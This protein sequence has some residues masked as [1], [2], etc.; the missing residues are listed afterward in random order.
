MNTVGTEKMVM[1]SSLMRFFSRIRKYP[2]FGVFI[3]FLVIFVIFSV[4]APKFLTLANL[5]GVFTIVSE[6]GII[7]IGV[8]LLM[9][10]GEFNLAVSGIYVFSAFLFATLANN[11]YSPLALLITL[12]VASFWGYVGGIITLRMH[13]P[14][15]IT[16]LGLLMFL[17]GIMLAITKGSSIDYRGDA[18][19]PKM[20]AK[21]I[22]GSF[23]PS[24]FWFI[25]LV[26]VFA[27]ILTRTR[28]GNWVFATGGAKEVARTMGVNVDRVKLINFTISGVLAGFSGCIVLSRFG[29]A[30]PSFGFGLELEAIAGA[31]IGGT[32]LTG[33]YGTIIGAALGTFLVGMLRIGLILAGAPAYWYQAFVGAILIIAAIINLKLR[34]IEI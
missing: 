22:G 2:A 5:T 20:L 17:R 27:F 30:N 15:F 9:I 4:I 26:L 3:A 24:H 10:S 23:R 16:T 32:L 7:T 18:V 31:V 14:S 13:I 33:G 1:Q 19:V 12:V 25:A 29:V 34:R 8:T 6:L 21:F 28:Y 11:I